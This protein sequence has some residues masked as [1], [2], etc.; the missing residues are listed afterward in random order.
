MNS[1]DATVSTDSTDSAVSTEPSGSPVSPAWKVEVQE[2]KSYERRLEVEVPAER[3]EEE[4]ESLYHDYARKVSVPGFRKGKVPRDILRARFGPAIEQE[5]VDSLIPKVYKDILKEKDLHPVSE[6]ELVEAKLTEQR[7]LRFQLT[8][9][10]VPAFQLKPYRGLTLYKR[11]HHVTPKDV[12]EFIASLRESKATLSPVERPAMRGDQLLVDLTP[13]DETGKL[14]ES[15]KMAN[16][17]LDLGSEGLLPEFNE[18]LEGL[19]PGA[20]MDI[21]VHY[22]ADFKE[23]D[24]AGKAVTYRAIVR[25]VKEKHLPPLDDALAKDL[26]EESLPAL[27]AKVE[28]DL[29]AEMERRAQ[30]DLEAQAVGTL[31]KENPV[32][33]PPSMVKNFLD[34]I[35]EDM[36]KRLPPEKWNEEKIR[37]ENREQAV[38]LIRRTL[39]LDE[40]AGKESLA[41]SEEETREKIETLTAL[42]PKQE[43]AIRAH[44]ARH[45]NRHRLEDELR[46]EKILNFLVKEA[47]IRSELEMPGPKILAPAEEGKIIKPWDA[48]KT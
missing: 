8:F 2:T 18:K 25:E 30:A 43:E 38:W 34:H 37:E 33:V 36:K 5:A 16:V 3:V 22:P 48:K 27:Q 39:L 45:K 44:Y 20:E 19:S 26:G 40:I 42:A 23:A 14:N 29:R 11:L 32:E 35:A 6:A 47:Q 13:R 15:K 28:A 41:P 17:P 1:N 9:E 21:E 12:E 7:S 4:V 46:E 31:I 24:L 10:V